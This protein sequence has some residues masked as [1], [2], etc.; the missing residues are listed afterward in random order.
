LSKIRSA[1]IIITLVSSVGV[2]IVLH[3]AVANCND[4]K[5]IFIDFYVVRCYD[6]QEIQDLLKKL[7]FIST[8]VFT[9]DLP[10]VD[11]LDRVHKAELKLR[12]KGLWDVPHPWL[13]LFVPKSRIRDFDKG[14]FKGI[15]GNKTSGP[16]LIYPMNKSK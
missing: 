12:S 13:N 1:C 6:E 2:L 3:F 4:K 15:L 11:F 16:I 10:Y 9:S 5:D 8:S 7:H 14:V